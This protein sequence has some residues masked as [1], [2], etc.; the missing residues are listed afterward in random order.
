MIFGH[1]FYSVAKL[2]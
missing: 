2:W 1:C